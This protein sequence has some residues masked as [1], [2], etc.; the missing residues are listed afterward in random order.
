MVHIHDILWIP[1]HLGL[2]TNLINSE[3]YRFILSDFKHAGIVDELLSSVASL[4]L[5]LGFYDY[6]VRVFG[7][8]AGGF[9]SS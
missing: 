7:F 6:V 1:T 4:R 8:G 3:L 2:H 5:G 9:H